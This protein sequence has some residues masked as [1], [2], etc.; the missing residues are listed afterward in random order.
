[1]YFLLFNELFSSVNSKKFQL[2][3]KLPTK[4]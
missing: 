2:T 1:L 4:N 3:V